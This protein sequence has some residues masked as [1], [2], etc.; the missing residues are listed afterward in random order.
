VN[1][2]YYPF[3]ETATAAESGEGSNLTLHHLNLLG[4]PRQSWFTRHPESEVEAPCQRSVHGPIIRACGS[5]WQ[6]HFSRLL[7]NPHLP[8]VGSLKPLQKPFRWDTLPSSR[9]YI[10]YPDTS[11]FA[12]LSRGR[13]EGQRI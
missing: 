7:G 9:P 11:A 8:D 1:V 12:D 13:F 6:L 10:N 3:V 5:C 2:R 4:A